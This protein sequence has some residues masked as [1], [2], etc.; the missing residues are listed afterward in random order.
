MSVHGGISKPRIA[1]NELN[2]QQPNFERQRSKEDYDFL[3][4]LSPISSNNAK[5]N[6]SAA[7]SQLTVIFKP[8]SSAVPLKSS[9]RRGRLSVLES[10]FSYHLLRAA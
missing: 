6:L 10:V 8:S 2:L 4:S 7:R 5:T 3:N 9:V 1:S